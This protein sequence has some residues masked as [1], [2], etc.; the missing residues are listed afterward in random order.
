MSTAHLP[1]SHKRQGYGGRARLRRKHQGTDEKHKNP[2][3]KQCFSELVLICEMN[4]NI[5][6]RRIS[7]ST[8][9]LDFNISYNVN[10]CAILEK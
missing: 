3:R 2:T 1:F 5:K 8:A 6:L 10:G 7:V 9:T 4:P